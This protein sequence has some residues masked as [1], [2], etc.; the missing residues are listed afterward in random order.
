M[1]QEDNLVDSFMDEANAD[2]YTDT[3]N[4]NPVDL[5]KEEVVEVQT[6][7][8]LLGTVFTSQAAPELKVDGVFGPAT[9]AR[10]RQFYTALPKNTQALLPPEDNPFVDLDAK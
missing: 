8:N 1:A 5:S 6:A 3:L 4:P 2:E 9:Y 10:W 7:L